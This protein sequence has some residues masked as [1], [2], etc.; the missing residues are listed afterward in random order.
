MVSRVCSA[1][2]RGID[3]YIVEVECFLSSGLPR[4][5]IVGLP[6]GAVAEAGERVRAALKHSGF[7]WPVSRLTVNLAPAD[8][9]KAGTAYDLPIALSILAA[10]GAIAKLPE[11]AVFLGELSLTGGVR[12]V[13]G[14]LSMALAAR[15]AG[16]ET[17]FV[18]AA[19]A[20]EAAY[21]S[22]VAV[23]PVRS[24]NELAAHLD[25]R[26]LLSPCPPPPAPEPHENKL[27]FAHVMGQRDVKRALEIAAAG[28]HNVLLSG[29]PGSGKSMMAK[30]FS[31]ILPPLT[32]AERLEVIRVW[33]AVGRGDEAARRAERPFRAPHHNSSA[34]A[35]A[36]GSGGSGRLPAPGE[37]TLAHRGVLFLDELPEFQR[38]VLETL[39]Q[40]LEDG[41]VTISRV[42]GQITYPAD[43][44]LIAAMNPCKCGWYGTPRCTC[45]ETSVRQ[46]LKRLSGPLLDRIDLQVAVQPVEYAALAARREASE[47]CSADIRRRVLRARETQY[48]RQGQ[49]VCNA[50][51]PPARLAELCPLSDSA[52]RMFKAAFE[53]LGLTA[54]AHDRVL[55]TAR[56]I[57]DLAGSEVLQAEHLAEALQ[58]RTLD[59][60]SAE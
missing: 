47:E 4:L 21:A 29:P 7:D 13:C 20:A 28:G 2:L 54:R 51:I 24:L 58:Y 44:Q 17:V 40:P 1:G 46:Y 39:R 10:Q 57:A 59:R 33:S 50:N 36:G 27:D 31:S 49:G 55:R 3:G 42:A 19:N 43:F 32:E 34:N 26:A 8:L 35:I 37:I 15:D 41:Q 5:D 48:A 6:T 30:R 18:P 45:S 23:L 56:T 9:K 16:F 11:R 25:G 38:D 12:P 14:A 60:I 53:R 52:S 22:G